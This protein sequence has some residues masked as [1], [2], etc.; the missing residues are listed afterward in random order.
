MRGGYIMKNCATLVFAI[1]LLPI[2]G[3]DKSSAFDPHSVLKYS[4][5]LGPR[6]DHVFYT[7]YVGIGIDKN[8]NAYVSTSVA[9]AGFPTTPDADQTIPSETAI[10]K[11]SA[12]GSKL[13]YSSF[14][15]PPNT[16]T[17]A[18]DMAVDDEGSTYLVGI[19]ESENFP[20]TDGSY[21]PKAIGPY[22]RRYPHDGFLIKL[23]S[24]LKKVIY[25]TYIGNNDWDEVFTVAVDSQGQAVLGG[26]VG[27]KA[28]TVY[29]FKAD[30]SG[31]VFEHAP[32]GTK[33]LGLIFDIATDASGC[34]YILG[35]TVQKDFYTTPGAYDRYFRRQQRCH[36]L[37]KL[38]PA[39]K[40]V[41]STFLRHGTRGEGEDHFY[42][43]SVAVDSEGCVYI[44]RATQHPREHTTARAFDTR[45]NGLYD[46][47]VLK[48]DPTGSRA[49]WCTY[50]GGRRDDMSKGL[51]V[52]DAGNVYVTGRTRSRDFPT[53]ETAL[54]KGNNGDFDMFLSVLD[55]SGGK[56]L[57]S[58]V[59]GGKDY[60]TGQA[61][62]LDPH[63]R[64]YIAGT[65][66]STDFPTTQR[67][68]KRTYSGV[69]TEKFGGDVFVCK[70]DFE[71]LIHSAK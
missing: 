69:K 8:G 6:A 53:T 54:D 4:T 26:D 3:S 11:L 58:T 30:G 32:L 14:F 47:Y 60:D 23:D 57:Y 71:S 33:G 20:A 29:K 62:A 50:L 61:L 12:D 43:N 10:S 70:L 55:A 49:Q 39:G 31:L 2:L 63:N 40:I 67:A 51:T 35:F 44:C 1:T 34:S 42:G 36:F 7:N 59:M 66:R 18:Y 46:A 45:H 64:L 48:L 15:G 52:D 13:I 68:Y 27:D 17:R 16:W 28:K 37:R 38:D 56:L 21:H 41:F 24:T 19:T 65:T 5:Y 25:G 9:Q 22:P